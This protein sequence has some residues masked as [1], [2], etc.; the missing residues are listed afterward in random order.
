MLDKYKYTRL[1]I[2]IQSDRQKMNIAIFRSR[3]SAVIAVAIIGV[4]IWIVLQNINQRPNNASLA[5]TLLGTVES[6]LESTPIT[7]LELFK[8][9]NSA[10][11][12]LDA[13]S[14]YMAYL[15]GDSVPKYKGTVSLS[16]PISSPSV[17]QGLD[18]SG[19]HGGMVIEPFLDTDDNS[20]REVR[21]KRWVLGQVSEGN[22][23]LEYLDT[24]VD[25]NKTS[26]TKPVIDDVFGKHTGKEFSDL[27]INTSR[28]NESALE[29]NIFQ[30]LEKAKMDPNV[31]TI[32]DYNE[33]RYALFTDENNRNDTQIN[34]LSSSNSEQLDKMIRDLDNYKIQKLAREFYF[35]KSVQEQNRGATLPT[36]RA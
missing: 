18:V 9:G 23:D 2:H 32:L 19:P 20:S 36:N 33:A 6:G 29:G 3:L 12:E 14:T 17:K 7:L 13:A 8:D 1:N 34:Q 4:L 26:E 35:L 22:L 21:D 15:S 31:K 11:I 30:K 25:M 10:N 24:F 16:N 28:R 27:L 5:T